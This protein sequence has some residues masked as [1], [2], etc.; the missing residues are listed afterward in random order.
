[1]YDNQGG[2]LD[3]FSSF[4]TLV[5]S[6]F[7]KHSNLLGYEL[8]NEPWAGAREEGGDKVKKATKR[9]VSECE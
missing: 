8:I 3:A 2:L 1:M 5:A 6:T 4:W 9:N 7:K